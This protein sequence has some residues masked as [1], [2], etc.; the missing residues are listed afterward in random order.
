MEPGAIVPDGVYVD[1]SLTR[2]R[3]VIALQPDRGEVYVLYSLGTDLNRWCLLRT[4][5]RWAKM[6]I[7]VDADGIILEKKENEDVAADV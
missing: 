2:W 7:T 1:A 6:R 3:R 5:C 4:F